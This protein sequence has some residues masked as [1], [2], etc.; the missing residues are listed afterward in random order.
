MRMAEFI[1][2][3]VIVATLPGLYWLAVRNW[4]PR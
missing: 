4:G 3:A 2:G 1:T